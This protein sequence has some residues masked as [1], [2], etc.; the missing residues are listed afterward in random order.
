MYIYEKNNFTK[1]SKSNEIQNNIK[2]QIQNQRLRFNKTGMAFPG[3][4]TRRVDVHP[5]NTWRRRTISKN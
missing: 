4:R 2:L 1:H 5:T 3:Y